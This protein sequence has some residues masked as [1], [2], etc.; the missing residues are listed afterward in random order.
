MWSS[1]LVYVVVASAR[2]T[3]TYGDG[4]SMGSF[5]LS[6]SSLRPRLHGLFLKDL[7]LKT[8]YNHKVLRLRMTT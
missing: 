3:A 6:P 5:R 4:G 8:G 2:T 1:K 7:S